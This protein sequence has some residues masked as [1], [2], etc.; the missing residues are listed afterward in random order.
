MIRQSVLLFGPPGSGKG[1]QATRLEK[2]LRSPH[3][4]TGDMFRDHLARRTEL[5][6]KVEHILK[7][8]HLVP[9]AVTNEMVRER[10]LRPDASL[11]V[12]LDG[13][14]RNVAQARW[15]EDF[16]ETR[17]YGVLGVVVI[18]VPDAEL[19]ERLKSRAAKEGRTDDA[20]ESVIR[21]RLATYAA[22]TAACVDFYRS[23]SVP[24]HTVNGL[25]SVD[26]VERRIAAALGLRAA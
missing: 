17:G 6:Q 10:L 13:F 18:D 7:S 26:E 11:G 8:G 15:L 4:S 16:L 19:I 20:D 12:I 2:T 23:V 9:D 25:G 5:G 22:Q 3:V 21:R 24:V 14:P 1:T